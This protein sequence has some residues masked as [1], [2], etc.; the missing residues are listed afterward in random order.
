MAKEKLN[1][2][3]AIKRPGAL[4]AK[5]GTSEGKKIPVKTLNKLAKRPGLT[6]QQARF[7]KTLRKITN[8]RK[9]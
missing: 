2:K 1:I 4:R 3:K 8:R 7:A 6:G 9:A 5:T